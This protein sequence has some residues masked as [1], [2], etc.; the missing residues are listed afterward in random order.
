M[1]SA[2]L[3]L[4]KGEYQ[5]IKALMDDLDHRR[6]TKQPLEWPSAGSTFRRPPGYFAGKLVQ[7]VGMRGF[8]NG[9]A[10]VSDL[11]CGFVINRGNATAQE[12]IDLI[13]M[14]QKRVKEKFGVEL[15]TEVKV[16]G[17]E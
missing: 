15:H 9:N 4:K 16:I 12:V 1:L 3:Q 8:S 13:S 17:E 10:Q 11:H 2:I 7:D 5:D 6:K 14:I